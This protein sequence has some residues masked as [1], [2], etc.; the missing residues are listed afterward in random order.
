[1]GRLLR[2]VGG[3]HGLGDLFVEILIAARRGGGQHH[4]L[5]VAGLGQRT[6]HIEVLVE[7]HHVVHVVDVH[8][9]GLQTLDL[10]DDTVGD[11]AAVVGLALT[12][13][14]GLLRLGGGLGLDLDALGLGRADG[15]LPSRAGRR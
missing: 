14:P 2:F 12:L 1:M 8:T 11:F 3:E 10:V 5:G 15:W 9:H 6:H 7:Q 13:Q 4:G